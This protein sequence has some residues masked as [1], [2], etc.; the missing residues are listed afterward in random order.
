VCEQLAELDL[1][2]AT[3]EACVEA[4]IEARAEFGRD[5]DVRPEPGREPARLSLH[6]LQLLIRSTGACR[7]DCGL[8]LVSAKLGAA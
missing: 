3:G 6:G 8:R 2:S 4:R 7:A 1:E 5:E